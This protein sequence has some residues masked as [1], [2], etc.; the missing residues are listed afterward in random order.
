MIKR[1]SKKD[2]GRAAFRINTLHDAVFATMTVE[3]RAAKDGGGGNTQNKSISTFYS[4]SKSA[5][6]HTL[7]LLHSTKLNDT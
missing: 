5:K 2:T 6:V 1:G 4:M 7:M 3:R